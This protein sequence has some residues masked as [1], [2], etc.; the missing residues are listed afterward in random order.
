MQQV[1]KKIILA[2]VVNLSN[3]IHLAENIQKVLQISSFATSCKPH[4][5][6]TWRSLKDILFM[7]VNS[8]L[9]FFF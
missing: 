6:K 3:E 4:L 5:L 9:F 7:L 1:K 2:R 8:I